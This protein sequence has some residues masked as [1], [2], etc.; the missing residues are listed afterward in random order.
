MYHLRRRLSEEKEAQ[1]GYFRDIV[2]CYWNS[3]VVCLLESK[4]VRQSTDDAY[5]HGNR[6][7]V[8]APDYGHGC[9]H[10]CRRPHLVRKGEPVIGLDDSDAKVSLQQAEVVLGDTMRKV[11]QFYGVTL[12][13]S[14]RTWWRRQNCPAK[15]GGRLQPQNFGSRWCRIRRKYY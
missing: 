3:A 5:V 15:G 13:S 14:A 8:D 1:A 2:C 4:S 9:S 12:P 7:S 6:Y 10:Q 11:R